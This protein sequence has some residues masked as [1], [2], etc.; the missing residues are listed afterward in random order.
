MNPAPTE[1]RSTSRRR[2]LGTTAMAL[3][4]VAGGADNP[5]V[6]IPTVDDQVRAAA[7]AA[8]L[9]LVFH[10]SSPEE[11][12]TW[13]R[14][15]SAELLQ[16]I[17]PHTPPAPANWTAEA[18]STIEFA[19]HFREE[20]LLKAEGFPSLPL[21]VLRPAHPAN[22]RLP[23]ILAI[24]GHGEFGNDAVV[25][26]DSTP[27]RAAEIKELNYDYGR[28]L[29]RQGYLVVAP[30][31][32]PFGRRLDSRLQKS[33]Q[34]QCATAFVRLLMLGQTLIGAN[35]R[36]LLWS[37]DYVSTRTDSRPDRIGCVGLS[38]GGRMTMMVA[39]L[40]PRIRVAVI[41]GALNVMQERILGQYSCGAQV[42]PGLLE[43]GDTP[44]I[45][46]LIAPRPCIWEV[47]SRDNLVARDW[48][49][50]AIARLQRAYAAAGQV[51][52]LSI[53]RFE[54]GH[55]WIGVTA[56]PLLENILKKG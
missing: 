26:I 48:A 19:D 52:Q 8:P 24:H 2:F 51:D 27:E 54:G 53:H 32:T 17:G 1:N 41:S 47:G 6:R 21:Y 44:E 11:L 25:G 46:S 34:D 3:C 16:R 14:Q 37:L 45:G 42:I 30:C 36:D 18:L 23:V 5:P 49:D 33:K 9:K 10:G 56:I 15:F 28:Q 43:I 40:D 13:Q 12:R 29:V 4:G 38:Y 39:A 50:Q 55:E 35:L 7:Q 22:Q 20:W 31:L